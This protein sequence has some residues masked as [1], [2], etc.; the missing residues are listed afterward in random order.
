MQIFKLLFF[1]LVLS[2][3]I[4]LAGKCVDSSIVETDVINMCSTS[5]D[6]DIICSGKVEFSKT[7]NV[8]G[9]AP[10][11]M[12][13]EIVAQ[14]GETVEEGQLIFKVYKQD[15]DLGIDPKKLPAFTTAKDFSNM[16]VAEAQALCEEYSKAIKNSEKKT[17]NN[18]VNS[19]KNQVTDIVSPTSGVLYS[20]DVREGDRV[21]ENRP[22]GTIADTSTIQIR[23]KINE[24]QI[25][26]IKEGQPVTITGAGFKKEVYFGNIKQ[27]SRK[28]EGNSENGNSDACVNT[29]VEIEDPDESIRL[30]F[31]AKCRITISENPNILFVPYK[32]VKTDDDGREF[33]FKY[34]NGKIIK[35]Y[36]KTG[37]EFPEGFEILSG[38]KN[39]DYVIENP[40][41]VNQGSLVKIRSIK[42]GNS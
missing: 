27:I 42:S 23:L 33:V 41:N 34:E 8:F 6:E 32:S 18:S 1:T 26:N 9:G 37:K 12:I 25:P 29:I 2:G 7:C 38:I 10:C 36:I 11:V 28:A 16:S 13:K 30:G 20:V 3:L 5:L 40:N 17:Q 31:T 22:L 35:V 14:E 24:S 39:G 15:I 4:F 19:E 21:L